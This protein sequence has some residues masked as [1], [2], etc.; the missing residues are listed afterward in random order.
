MDNLYWSEID[1]SKCSSM[2]GSKIKKRA[3]M[4]AIFNLKLCDKLSLKCWLI[5]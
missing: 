3:S 4:L 2:W 5:A 1:E